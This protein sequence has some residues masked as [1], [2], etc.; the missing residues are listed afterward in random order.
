MVGTRLD[1][2]RFKKRLLASGFS[3]EQSDT[4]LAALSDAQPQGTEQPQD[5]ET[6]SEG[7]VTAEVLESKLN[8]MEVRLLVYV[9]LM[10]I[11]ALTILG[12]LLRSGI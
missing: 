7:L 1:T 3:D 9:G 8:A 6:K 10:F 2:A 11:V 12:F 4:A 5:T